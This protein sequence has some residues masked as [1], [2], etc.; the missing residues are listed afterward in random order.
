MTTA[1]ANTTRAPLARIAKLDALCRVLLVVSFVALAVTGIG[2]YYAL[3]AVDGYGLLVHMAAGG[4]FTVCLPVVVLTASSSALTR[5]NGALR[6]LVYWLTVLAAL[7]ALG[8]ITLSMTKLFDTAG[9]HDLL[10]LHRWAGLALVALS[11]L[12][13][14]L[15]VACR[16]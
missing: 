10:T 15:R 3:G 7:V 16:R 2:G 5:P 1:T 8:T 6:T 13:L 11:I 4:V 14:F 9:L 12:Q